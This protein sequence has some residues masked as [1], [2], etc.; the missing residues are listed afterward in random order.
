MDRETPNR[1]YVVGVDRRPR[2]RSRSAYSVA[3]ELYVTALKAI[4]ADAKQRVNDDLPKY[5]EYVKVNVTHTPTHTPTH[6]H[7]RHTHDTHTTHTLSHSK[8]V[9]IL[10]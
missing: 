9:T 5:S 10:P 6:T 7:T 4:A 3:D 2:T 8:P 1:V